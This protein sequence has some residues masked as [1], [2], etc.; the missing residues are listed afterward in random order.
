MSTEFPTI[1]KQ[2]YSYNDFNKTIT[3]GITLSLLGYIGFTFL[4]LVRIKIKNTYVSS[5]YFQLRFFT[6]KIFLLFFTSAIF[7]HPKIKYSYLDFK[8]NE[9]K[10]FPYYFKKINIS[11]FEKKKYIFDFSGILTSYR[12]SILYKIN[13]NSKYFENKKIFQLN[14]NN[15]V[16]KFITSKRHKNLIYF[17]L[18]AGKKKLALLKSSKDR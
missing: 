9:V 18:H 6:S 2:F 16:G 17:F 10:L 1:T 8:K 3:K 11:S 12:L 15:K 5:M 13:L 7:A 14:K 4:N